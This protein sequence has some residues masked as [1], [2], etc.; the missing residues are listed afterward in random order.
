M[1]PPRCIRGQIIGTEQ[2]D[3]LVLQ[4]FLPTE[5]PDSDISAIPDQQLAD[6]LGQMRAVF[7]FPRRNDDLTLVECLLPLRT[8]SVSAQISRPL[9]GSQE[10]RA[11]YSG[12]VR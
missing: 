8:M 5:L 2:H 7:P 6:Y 9:N 12:A 11:S 3:H 1:Q 4:S 10:M